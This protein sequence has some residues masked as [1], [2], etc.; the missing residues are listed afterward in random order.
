MG[1]RFDPGD[2]RSDDLV[3]AVHAA[4][5]SITRTLAK[6]F[7]LIS[8]QIAD[9]QIS[10]GNTDAIEASVAQLKALTSQL[11]SSI[12]PHKGT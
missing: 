6:G 3:E 12:H 9:A 1:N 7:E 2:R 10:T 4:A 8:A 5:Q 11:Q